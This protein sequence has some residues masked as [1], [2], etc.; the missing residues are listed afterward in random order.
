M[1][2]N[3]TAREVRAVRATRDR[4]GHAA[5]CL[6]D[7]ELLDFLRTLGEP[8]TTTGP[9]PSSVLVDEDPTSTGPNPA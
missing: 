2:G 4:F 5:D 7:D 6:P 8:P 1:G 9:T 3:S